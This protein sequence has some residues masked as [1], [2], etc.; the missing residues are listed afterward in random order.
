MEA[1][2]IR[3]VDDRPKTRCIP[4]PRNCRPIQERP[5]AWQPPPLILEHFRLRR[6]LYVGA[7]RLGNQSV[8]WGKRIV[9]RSQL[10]KGAQVDRTQVIASQD[11]LKDPF[12]VYAHKFTVFV[13]GRIGAV[14]ARRR[15]LENIIEEEKPAHTA[16]AIE[17]VKPRYIVGFQSMI[18]FDGV[19][20][21]Y[22][23]GVVADR[24]RLADGSVLTEEPGKRCGPPLQ[25]GTTGRIGS[26]TRLG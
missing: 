1:E 25:V 22:P 18:G 21:D 6:W 10:N 14:E 3:C 15:A 17:Y 5:C 19:I 11:P 26:S 23:A 4:K 16:G 12:H 24:T 8:L 7:G 2:E 13:P 9:N 20:G